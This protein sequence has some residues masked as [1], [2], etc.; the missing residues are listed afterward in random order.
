MSQ[1]KALKIIQIYASKGWGGGEKY[2][3]DLSHRLVEEGHSV[4]SISKKCD[5]INSKIENLGSYHQLPM[6]GVIDLYS[7]FLLAQIIKKE[8]PDII[9]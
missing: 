9:H 2:V 4:V 1:D 5:V 3:L 8:N 7:S 6:K